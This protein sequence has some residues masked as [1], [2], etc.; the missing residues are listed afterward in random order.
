MNIDLATMLSLPQLITLDTTIFDTATAKDT[1]VLDNP[2]SAKSLTF[3]YSHSATSIVTITAGD[4]ADLSDGVTVDAKWL[5][6]WRK[7]AFTSPFTYTAEGTDVV[8][9]VGPYRYVKINITDPVA[10]TSVYAFSHFLSKA[11]IVEA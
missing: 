7:D 1:N 5:T 11:P 4:A 8:G 10:G 2:V 3:I 9:Y 6:N